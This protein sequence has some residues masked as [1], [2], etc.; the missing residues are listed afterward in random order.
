MIDALLRI[1]LLLV[2]LTMAFIGMISVCTKQCQCP[3]G[4]DLRT[5][6]RRDGRFECWPAPIGDPEWDGTYDRPERSVQPVGVIPGR[7]SCESGSQPVVSDWRT[8][9]CAP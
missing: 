8:V 4:T 5:G 3:A 2:G 7:I 9:E 1:M 6:V